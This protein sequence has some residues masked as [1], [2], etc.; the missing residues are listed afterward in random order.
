MLYTGRTKVAILPRAALDLH[1]IYL[2]WLRNLRHD[3]ALEIIQGILKSIKELQ[4]FYPAAE[5]FQYEPLRS[6]AY[7]VLRS[8][9]YVCVCRKVEHIIYVYHVAHANTEYPGLFEINLSK[10]LDPKNL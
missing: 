7:R 8:T 2:Y 10:I 5:R 1:S 4:Y 3:G 6:S 9:E